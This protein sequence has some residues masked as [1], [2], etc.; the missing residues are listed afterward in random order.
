[1]LTN[2]ISAGDF[3]LFAGTL[4]GLLAFTWPLFIPESQFFLLQHDYARLLAVLIAGFGVGVVALEISRGAM[5]A[6]AVA[7]L[8]VLAAMVAALRLVGAGAVGVEPMWF[9][10]ILASYS[11]GSKFGFAL[12]IVSMATSAIIT[13][14]I[15]VWLPFQMIAAGWIGWL[16]GVAGLI[17]GSIK[18]H[19]R[20]QKSILVSLG[21]FCSLFFG[22]LMDLQLW[23]W[24]AG[25][26][27]QLSYVAGAALLENFQRFL[28]F[29]AATAFSWD[30]PRAITTALLIAI[31]ARPLLNS[32]DRAKLRLNLISHVREQKVSA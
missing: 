3:L 17:T 32:F 18:N 14:G 23:P 6:K 27:T 22:A 7:I 15:G 10:L 8:G 30:I 25:T 5:D 28:L 20:F 19:F 9:L 21:V 16:S 26:D 1:M 2:K 12:G 4:L 11:F 31:T 13:G 29:H 24:L